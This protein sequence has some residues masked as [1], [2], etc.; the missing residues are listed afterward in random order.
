MTQEELQQA[1]EKEFPVPQDQNY[2][3]LIKHN[4]SVWIKGITS[5][6]A[7]RYWEEKLLQN[8]SEKHF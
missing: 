2:T 3:E 8:N 7:K 5:E 6:T 4:R 1:A